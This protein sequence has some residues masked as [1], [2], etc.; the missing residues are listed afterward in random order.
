M[1][2]ADPGNGIDF[3]SVARR[4]RPRIGRVAIPRQVRA[5][6]VIIVQVILDDPFQ[7]LFGQHDYVVQTLATDRPDKSLAIR[8]LPG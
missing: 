5:A 1:E 8:V 4:Y 2:S 6:V 7:V 3:A